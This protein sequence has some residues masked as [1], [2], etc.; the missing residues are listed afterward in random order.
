[1]AGTKEGGEKRSA[2]DKAKNKERVREATKNALG[3]NKDNPGPP[4]EAWAKKRG[5]VDEDD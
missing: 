4:S 1:M 5:L 3:K 2:N